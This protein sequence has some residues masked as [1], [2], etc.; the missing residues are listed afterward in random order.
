M[1]RLFGW[2]T[3]F[4]L[5]PRISNG[6]HCAL[7][8]LDEIILRAC[9]FRPSIQRYIQ[10]LRALIQVI[11][12][13]L[14]MFDL[15]RLGSLIYQFLTAILITL[16]QI[17]LSLIYFI[18][19]FGN[20]DRLLVL[21][22]TH[23]IRKRIT[24]VEQST[25]TTRALSYLDNILSACL[26]YTSRLINASSSSLN[27]QSA[28]SDYIS[29]IKRILS[30]HGSAPGLIIKQVQW[31]M[32]S[33]HHIQS[34]PGD[35]DSGLIDVHTRTCLEVLCNIKEIYKRLAMTPLDYSN[36]DH[37]QLLFKV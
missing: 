4:R 8:E 25:I 26:F 33:K 17:S 35:I 6:I 34:A 3:L 31:V 37:R 13:M 7:L 30:Q 24:L 32:L 28:S 11:L 22:N 27:V 14:I 36:S 16:V 15:E 1:P 18:S 12:P 23:S 29:P 20:I 19:Y 9:D 21:W 5:I 10:F 2:L